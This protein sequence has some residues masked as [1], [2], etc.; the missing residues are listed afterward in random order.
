VRARPDATRGGRD[1]EWARHLRGLVPALAPAAVADVIGLPSQIITSDEED[2]ASL[3]VP[4][5]QSHSRRSSRTWV[6]IWM[7]MAVS[8]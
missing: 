5:L 4:D 1:T 6:P 8:S 2:E 7:H 3:P